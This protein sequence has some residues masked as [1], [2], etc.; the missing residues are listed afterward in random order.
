MA[1]LTSRSMTN[2]VEISQNYKGISTKSNLLFRIVIVL[3]NSFI[4]VT[5]AFYF[6]IT[7]NLKVM[8]FSRDTL[9]SDSFVGVINDVTQFM[10]SDLGLDSFVFASGFI[11]DCGL[12]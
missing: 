7:K 6:F 8:S 2:R 10:T 9:V 11:H 1:L 12:L 5:N 4:L 3:H